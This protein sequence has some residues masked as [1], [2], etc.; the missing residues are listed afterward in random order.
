M[1][2]RILVAAL[3]LWPAL[4]YAQ[5][6]T[7]PPLEFKQEN[8]SGTP[9]YPSTVKVDHTFTASD[10]SITITA[11]GGGSGD[12]ILIGGTA[13]MDASGVDLIG[14]TNGLDI[15]FDAG[16]SPD[17]ATFNLDA[18]EIEAVTFGAGGNASNL[19][20]VNLSGTDPTLLWG[21]DA[22][23]WNAEDHTIQ[24]VAPNYCLDPDT[25]T[26]TCW[27]M[28]AGGTPSWFGDGDTR[29]V[30]MNSTTNE[31]TFGDQ[32]S[33][34]ANLKVFTSGNS[35][36]QG[37]LVV[38]TNTLVVDAAN[39][40]VLIGTTALTN[41]N[42]SVVN[43]NL[44]LESNST[45]SLQLVGAN[46]NG[47]IVTSG[48]S[49]GTLTAPSDAV[50]G[51]VMLSLS[52][53]LYAGGE[54]HGEVAMINLAVDGTPGLGDFPSRIE[55]RT[56][57]DG[58]DSL[59]QRMVITNNGTIRLGPN[60][61]VTLLP[62]GDGALELR[63]EGNGADECL[64]LNLDDTANVADFM[65]CAS[66]T[67]LTTYQLTNLDF[68]VTGTGPNLGGQETSGTA[69]NWHFGANQSWFSDGNA[70]VR[71]IGMDDA[72]NR[73]LLGENG[74]PITRLDVF[75]DSTG[76]GEVN[77]PTDS[78]GVQ[79]LDATDEPANDE[80]YSFDSATGRGQWDA[81]G[82]GS[83]TNADKRFPI[84]ASACE[85]LEAADS[86]PPLTKT[87]GTNLDIFT[88][89]FDA[90]TDEGCKATIIIPEDVQSGSTITFGFVWFSLTATT[91]AAVWDV[92]YTATGADGETW[93]AA[94]TTETV[95]C[96]VAG[97]VNL[98]DICEVTETLANTGWASGDIISV[99]IY[100][101][102][103]NASDT[104]VG[105]AELEMFYVVVPRA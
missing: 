59:V 86:I 69:F 10:N 71:Y 97:T 85:P 21:S 49:G 18:T 60:T 105:D 76:N 98:R 54:W 80:V 3:C 89:S 35:I 26:T 103:N 79:E 70:D 1:T 87:T 36:L 47:G 31:V 33:Q 4:A 78:I 50:S 24:G 75:T 32:G 88:R 29:F 45:T 81:P 94:L 51:N 39:N 57:P 68:L 65:N 101:D 61:G 34:I 25:G 22:V 41:S 14:G 44:S 8:G 66:S 13:V 38:D 43:Y 83:D 52:G 96:T 2:R 84:P 30:L 6:T 104:L 19:W 16:V 63:G 74:A 56:T 20:T 27:H 93:D 77:L 58:L 55:F 92:R 11:G 28:D 37:G 17:T 40:Y 48:V 62:D 90:A 99:M 64:A 91:N 100:R 46:E 7:A 12:P 5:D 23:T 15:A 95:T 73:L 67:G 72:A 9:R 53:N 82:A 102:A 42:P